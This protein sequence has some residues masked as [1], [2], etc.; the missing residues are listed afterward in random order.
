MS[1]KASG[2]SRRRTQIN[3]P[4]NNLVLQQCLL[5]IGFAVLSNIWLVNFV[6]FFSEVFN[7][8]LHMRIRLI[9]R[10]NNLYASYRT[11]NS[12]TCIFE[13]RQKMHKVKILRSYF[14][15]SNLAWNKN[16]IKK[17]SVTRITTVISATLGHILARKFICNFI[18]IYDELSL[19][20]N[21]FDSICLYN[22][23]TRNW[24]QI[25]DI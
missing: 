21:L 13:F 20:I 7:V 10:L 17:C 6:N 23:S 9:H 18:F 8:V 3:D 22:I 11:F 2:E 14:P 4:S 15:V 5:S 12:L 25:H 19:N 16:T 1:V 24:D